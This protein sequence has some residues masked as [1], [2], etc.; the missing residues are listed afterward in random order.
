MTN[1]EVKK[2]LEILRCERCNR[3]GVYVDKIG[4]RRCTLC[5]IKLKSIGEIIND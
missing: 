1:Y 5:K 2:V 4:G 3:R